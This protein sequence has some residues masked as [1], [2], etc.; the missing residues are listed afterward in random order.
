ML[1]RIRGRRVS[2]QSL[3]PVILVSVMGAQRY[4]AAI[5]PPASFRLQDVTIVWEQ[6]GGLVGNSRRLTVHG[7]GEAAYASRETGAEKIDRKFSVSRDT[8]RG[9]VEEMFEIY[10]FDFRTRY[11]LEQD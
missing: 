7:T 5:G 8:V 9:I 3:V 4:P 10:F 1:F 2:M 6:S 11:S